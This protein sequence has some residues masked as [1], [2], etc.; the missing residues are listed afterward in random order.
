VAGQPAG[1]QSLKD[2][3]ITLGTDGKLAL[4]PTTFDAKFA[5]NSEEVA[6]LFLAVGSAASEPLQSLTRSV[7]GSMALKESELKESIAAYTERIAAYD[8]RMDKRRALYQ[9]QFAEMERLTAQ[10]QSQGN[11]LTG[12]VNGL[13]KSSK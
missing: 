1:F 4:N 13:N 11:A 10:F 6:D 3:G 7:D 5:E 8:L 9:A 2:L 12:F